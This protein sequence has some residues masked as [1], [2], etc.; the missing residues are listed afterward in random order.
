MPQRKITVSLLLC[1]HTCFLLQFLFPLP[2]K[3]QDEE[4]SRC[5]KS[6][7]LSKRSGVF[8]KGTERGSIARGGK[9]S[10]KLDI[11]SS[12][13]PLLKRENG[14]VKYLQMLLFQVTQII[15]V[16]EV[17]YL[18]LGSFLWSVNAPSCPAIHC[19]LESI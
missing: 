9:H 15:C 5:A 4:L 12:G 16:N 17:F 10:W 19:T 11:A 6:K 1:R 3:H 14:F 18:Q 7:L 13:F 2:L 8:P